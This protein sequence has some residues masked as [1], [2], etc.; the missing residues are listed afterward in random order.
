MKTFKLII[1]LMFSL[2]CF[3]LPSCQKACVN[4]AEAPKS[5]DAQPPTNAKPMDAVA[6]SIPNIDVTGLNDKQ[7][8]ALSKLFNEEVCPCSCPKSLSQCID[9]PGCKPAKLL[10][11]WTADQLK[12]GAPEHLLFTAVNEEIA[13]FLS[14]EKTIDLKDAHRKGNPNAPIVIVEHADFECPMCKLAAV[15]MNAFLKA[16]ENDVQLY[17][18]H[19]PLS[20][21]ENAE[22]AA[23]A[24]EAAAKAGKFWEMHD[25]LFAHQGPLTDEAIKNIAMKIF[26]M[27]QLKQFEKDLKDPAL[28]LKI[29]KQKDYASGPLALTGTPSFLFNGRPYNL[30]IDKD[31]FSLRLAMEKH[32]KDMNCSSTK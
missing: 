30:S 2:C 22:R 7:I 12:G 17:F 16:N 14:Q 19:F 26:D 31:G 20:T 10:A 18:M 32:R 27:K 3:I 29:R 11:Q 5:N 9:M 25:L 23:V 13:G 6:A 28:L 15:E 21:H 4:K 24:A 8:F 1:G